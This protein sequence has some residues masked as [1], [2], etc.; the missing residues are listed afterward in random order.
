MAVESRRLAPGRVPLAGARVDVAQ[1]IRTAVI[2]NVQGSSF[3][4]ATEPFP[5]PVAIGDHLFY[6]PLKR[7]LDVVVAIGV[8]L[9]AGPMLLLLAAAV[10]L[11][12]R[13][14]ALYRARRVGRDGRSIVVLKFRTMRTDSEE[15]LRRLLEDPVV[16]AE[17]HATF[18]LR[19]DPRRTRLGALLRKTSLDELPQF[20]NVL[21]GEMTLVGPRPIV[22]DE[23]SLYRAVPGGAEAYLAVKPGITGLWQ[24]SGRCDTTYAER[25]RLDCEYVRD[26]SLALD[27]AILR[28]TPAAALG[29]EGAY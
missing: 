4:A 24:V 18:K 1:P 6:E 16:A 25:V 10:M 7:A 12:S 9:V 8:L 5:G 13:G 27:L 29:G 17:F 15:V 23:L 21:R 2:P 11:D 22:D 3:G 26:R 14:P 19:R 28:R 20:V